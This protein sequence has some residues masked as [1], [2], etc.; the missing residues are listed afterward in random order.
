M[1][2]QAPVLWATPFETGPVAGGTASFSP[3]P[4]LCREKFRLQQQKQ[5]LAGSRLDPP[6]QIS[7]NHVFIEQKQGTSPDKCDTGVYLSLAEAVTT[8]LGGT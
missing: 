8:N 5:S 2:V 6:E 3:K 1:R 4:E 7:S